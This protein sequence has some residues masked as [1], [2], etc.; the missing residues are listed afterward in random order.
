MDEAL[1]RFAGRTIESVASCG[2]GEWGTWVTEIV[3]RFRGGGTASVRVE[4]DSYAWL[5]A[6]TP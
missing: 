1:A 3:F 2:E 5:E 6:D 4:G